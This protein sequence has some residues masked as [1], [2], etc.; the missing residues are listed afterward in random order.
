MSP[1]VLGKVESLKFV[2]LNTNTGPKVELLV[3]VSMYMV[4]GDFTYL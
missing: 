2:R 1:V 3:K 4:C